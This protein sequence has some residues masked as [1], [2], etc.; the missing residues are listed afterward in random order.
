[1]SNIIQFPERDRILTCIESINEAIAK[2]ANDN[3]DCY[4]QIKV[5]NNL[6]SHYEEYEPFPEIEIIKGHILQATL[7]IVHFHQD[8]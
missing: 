7:M 6:L 8:T 5:L 1:M 2:D 3:N 4:Y